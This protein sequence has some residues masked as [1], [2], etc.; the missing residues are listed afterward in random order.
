MTYNVF[1]RALHLT[2][3]N[4]SK[5]SYRG[6]GE[7]HK[8]PTENEVDVL[9]RVRKPP[10]AIILSILNRPRSI[11]IDHKTILHYYVE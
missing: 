5:I 4:P 7:R 8:L 2:L 10:A 6:F 3:L 9:K 1:D 11:I